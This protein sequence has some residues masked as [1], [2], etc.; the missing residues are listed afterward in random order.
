MAR[1]T[2]KEISKDDQTDRIATGPKRKIA[3]LPPTTCTLSC[4][5]LEPLSSEMYTLLGLT[6]GSNPP[7]FTQLILERVAAGKKIWE[8]AGRAVFDIGE[9]LVAKIGGDLDHDEVDAMRFLA[10]RAPSLRAPR[11]LGFVTIGKK[12]LLFMTKIPGDTLER[13]WPTLNAESKVYLQWS[14]DE[15]ISK[16]RGIEKP[17][18]QPFG[19][20]SGRCRDT[21][22]SDRY[23]ESPVHDEVAFNKFLLTSLQSRISSSYKSWIASMLRTDHRIVFTHGDLHPR[24]ILVTDSPDGGVR[25]SGIIDWEASGFYPEYWEHLKA[26]NTRNIRDES[27]WWTHLPSSVVGYDQEIAVDR[28]LER[29][30]T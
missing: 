12:S 8:L 10:E 6:P 28:L 25:L 30:L 17:E 7:N 23:T 26:L 24:N 20:S 27:D 1:S 13:R 22:M 2:L 16:L 11:C 9:G 4:D 3:H 18:G 29:S 5:I 15:A 19:P 21:R 14:L